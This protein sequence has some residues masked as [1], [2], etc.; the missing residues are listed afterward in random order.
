MIELESIR[1][2][3]LNDEEIRE[4]FLSLAGRENSGQTARGAGEF[5]DELSAQRASREKEL[6][7]S[8]RAAE[9]ENAAL[10]KE[11]KEAQERA[12]ALEEEC[13]S[14]REAASRAEA[15]K[16]AA[17]ERLAVFDPIRS[18]ME[19]YSSLD[20]K[21]KAA[22]KNIFRT[23]S[24]DGFIS[25][26]AQRDSLANLWDYGRTL[27]SYGSE[28]CLK[29]DRL[30]GYF[31]SLY[32]LTFEQPVYTLIEPQTGDRFDE[33]F[34][35]CLARGK[36]IAAVS[37]VLLRGYRVNGKTVNKALVK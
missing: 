17:A 23:A 16:N 29:I 28:D 25:C 18:A 11:L 8:V 27:A 1:R 13:G 36:R 14:L 33:D 26:G 7:N 12:A 5:P 35:V 4:Y 30:F 37:D 34:H 6:E 24:P 22:T 19:I 2:F 10:R 15:E 32:N 20:E 21:S 3:I 31:V 9:L